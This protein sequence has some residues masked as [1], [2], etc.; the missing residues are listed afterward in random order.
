[1][2]RQQRWANATYGRIAIQ[3]KNDDQSP[4][5]RKYTTLCMR[6]P[7][8]L[9]QS[10]LVQALA[11]VNRK[12]ETQL[13]LDDFSAVLGQDR[14]GLT[15]DQLLRLSREEGLA[16]YMALTRDALAIAVWFRRFAQSELKGDDVLTEES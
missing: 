10:G 4:A 11:F 8:L 13:F 12:Q 6:F 1:M 3:A 14:G 15:R 16:S 5:R 7:T 9:M 2:T